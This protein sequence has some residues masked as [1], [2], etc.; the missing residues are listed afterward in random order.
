MNGILVKKQTTEDEK[1]PAKRYR[2]TLTEEER[3]KLS[4][5]VQYLRQ[6]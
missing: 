3:A 4:A 5:I 6:K 1:M 2:V